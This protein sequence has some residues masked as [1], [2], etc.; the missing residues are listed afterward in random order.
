V[1]PD[2]RFSIIIGSI[3][4]MFTILTAML[5]LLVKVVVQWTRTESRI[6]D[7]TQDVK[8]L[9]ESSDKRITWLEQNLWAR[10]R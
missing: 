3:G 9:T 1:T 6:A 4:L 8:N 10:K 5:G 2:Q 7:L